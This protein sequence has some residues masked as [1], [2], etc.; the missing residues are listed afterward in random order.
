MTRLKD[1]RALYRIYRTRNGPIT[2]ARLAWIVT[3]R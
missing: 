3:R 2:A 1:F